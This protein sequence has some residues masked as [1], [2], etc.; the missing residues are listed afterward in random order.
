MPGSSSDAEPLR[1]HV[2]MPGLDILRGLAV[3]GVVVFH[4]FAN[5]GF[6]TAHSGFATVF[7]QIVSLGKLGVYLFFILSGFL[8]TSILLKQRDRPDFYKNF[9]I[10]RALRILPVY[11]L[12]L[13]VLKASGLV[14]WRF[15]AA[16][17]LFVANMARLVHSHTNEYG[18]LW[19]LAVEE[20][21]YLLWPTAVRRLRSPGVLLGAALAGCALAPLLRIALNLRDVSTYTFLPT[22]MDSLLYG[23]LCAILIASGRLHA[24]NLRPAIR[25]LVGFGA[26]FLVPYV[27]LFCFH[28]FP[29][30]T[31]WPFALWDAF[32]RLDPFCFF[33]A[34]VLLSVEA[35]QRTQL[36]PTAALS[37]FLVFLGYISYGLYLVHPLL[38]GV[39]DRLAA[40]TALGGFHTGFAL[41]A[42]RFLAVS[43]ASAAVAFLSRRYF[44]QLFLERKAAL[45][46]YRSEAR[47][48]A[49][50]PWPETHA[51]HSRFQPL[52]ASG[53]PARHAP[54]P[55]AFQQPRSVPPIRP[56]G[57]NAP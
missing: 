52:N 39:Y 40:G 36:A 6:D 42:V 37:R 34:G 43:A 38:F 35:A 23:A 24:G 11:L 48:A 28:A 20:Q 18:A 49:A 27:H 19:T 12:L 45:A 16:C 33:A 47:T 10:R 26:I 2:H 9:Y 4:G 3:A 14:H 55:V 17:L 13:L 44:E 46:P 41:L 21:F 53:D 8:I 50:A 25:L 51:V 7:I 29:P 57:R 31:S 15:V 30:Q 54:N 56:P 32:G 22:N 1:L 5:G